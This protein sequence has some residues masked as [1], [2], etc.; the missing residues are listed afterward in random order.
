[1]R[2]LEGTE[3]GKDNIEGNVEG[4]SIRFDVGNN[5]FGNDV[6]TGQT[7]EGVEVEYDGIVEGSSQSSEAPKAVGKILC[8]PLTETIVV[9]GVADGATVGQEFDNA[10]GKLCIIWLDFLETINLDTG[11][12]IVSPIKH[13]YFL[14]LNGKN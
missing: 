14:V 11:A 2:I 4:G 6:E 5:V 10:L 8:G 1:M 3:E 13:K 7:E 9:V 12:R